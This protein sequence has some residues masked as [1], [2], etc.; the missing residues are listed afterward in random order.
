MADT[1]KIYVELENTGPTQTSKAVG[2]V[3]FRAEA[4]GTVFYPGPGRLGIVAIGPNSTIT[5]P[6]DVP[7]GTMRSHG[8]VAVHIWG[9]IVY[10][11]VFPDTP[12]R[13]T[14]FCRQIVDATPLRIGTDDLLL[15]PESMEFETN[16]PCLA[17]CSGENCPD[18]HNCYDEECPDYEERLTQAGFELPAKAVGE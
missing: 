6:F 1:A 15:N 12:S 11:D 4:R 10:R 9:R 18:P 14:E 13:L 17:S 8:G 16:V 7:I 2:N 5:V 3:Y